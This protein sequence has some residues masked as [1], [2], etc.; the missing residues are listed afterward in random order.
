MLA[1]SVAACSSTSTTPPTTPGTVLTKVTSVNATLDPYNPMVT[2]Q[3]IPA[4][5]V[6]FNLLGNVPP[7]R[8][9]SCQVSVLR[10]GHLVGT[11]TITGGTALVNPQTNMG[12]LPGGGS[13]G[14]SVENIKGGTFNGKPSDAH[15][16]CR[17]R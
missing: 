3:G 16:V 12:P 17:L 11:T 14:V 1:S 4:E 9:V 13:M 10:F 6:D 8:S 7:N 15:V 2:N 5:Q